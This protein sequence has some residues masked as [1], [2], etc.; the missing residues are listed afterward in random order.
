MNK[1]L[2]VVSVTLLAVPLAAQTPPTQKPG[3]PPPTTQTPPQPPPAAKPAAP[4]GATQ[5]AAR[6][7]ITLF[8]TNPAGQPIPDA[9]IT[10]S[11]I[12]D[13]AAV[14]GREGSAR[15]SNLRSGT[16]RARVDA[17]DYI[18]LEKELV[19]RAGQSLEAEVML[20]PAPVKKAEPPPPPPPPKPVVE[21]A[22]EPSGEVVT[23]SLSDWLDA[24][25]IGR[26]EGQK[27]SPVAQTPGAS[28]TVLQLR[29][30][31][32]D[33][34]HSEADEML[35]VIAGEAAMRVGDRTQVL[36]PGWFVTIPRGTSF[37]LERRG[38]NPLILLSIL[39]PAR[40][41]QAAGR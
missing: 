5:A 29:E 36:A 21:A 2:T 24:N 31:V 23:L 35:Y 4:A 27:G 17:A 28:A 13:R 41:A 33:R 32:T 22:A 34:A 19:L 26:T 38:R 7:A 20:N 40:G 9:K 25:L 10:L 1:L 8:V 16:Y 18:L 6:G 37:S 3:T 12:A 15:M 39:A 11:G 30:S 14:T